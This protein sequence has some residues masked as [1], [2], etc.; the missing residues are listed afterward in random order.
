MLETIDLPVVARVE[1]GRS[2]TVEPAL[3]PSWSNAEQ[4]A[5]QAAVV[6]LD[7]GLT[8]RLYRDDDLGLF[9]VQIGRSSTSASYSFHEMWTL[10]SGVDLGARSVASGLEVTSA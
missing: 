3:D 4:I 10:L 8:V 5:W 9:G 6:A 1:D 2:I 7:T